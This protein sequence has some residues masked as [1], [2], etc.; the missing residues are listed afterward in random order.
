MSD[1]PTIRTATLDR[2]IRA[3]D[4]AWAE[5]QAIAKHRHHLFI[6]CD[7][8]AAYQ[9]LR[10][11]RSRAATFVELGSGAGI[12][13]IMADLLGFEAYGIEIEPWLAGRSIEIAAHFDSGAVFAEGTFVPPEYQ[14]EI[15]HLSADNHTPTTGACALEEL[16]LELSDFDLLFAYPWPGDEDWLQELVRRHARAD[17]I[18]LTYDVSEGFRS[19]VAPPA[20]DERDTR[21]SP[22]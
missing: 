3:G 1:P 17:A 8:R 5:F 12:V 21:S 15:E 11:I 7:H 22:A 19:T 13:T 10:E 20:P 18:L 14:E 4:E 9:A 6:P 2:L 16:G